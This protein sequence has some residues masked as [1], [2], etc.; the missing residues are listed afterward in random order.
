MQVQFVG[1]T[2]GTVRKPIV[3][4]HG[5]P[6]RRA[7]IDQLNAEEFIAYAARV[8]NPA[9]QHN[10]AT[11]DKLLG[12][13]IRNKHW[14][15]FEM[16]SM[17]VEIT[18]S[19][20]IAPQILRHRSF[21]FQEFSLRYAEAVDFEV[22]EARRQDTKNRQNSIDDMS[23]EDK[24]WF[25]ETQALINGACFDKY[26]QAINRGIAKEQARFLLP[27]STQTKLYMS[28]TARSWIHY[29]DVRDQTGVQKEHRDI[30]IECKKIFIANFPHT[31]KALEWK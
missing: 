20:G 13:L 12:Y 2:Q 29:I 17:A 28:G 9:N 16:V 14:S 21:S 30:A 10:T 1:I 15:P 27:L 19:R 4:E 6:E 7:L 24:A 26:K 8:S 18:T 11:T 22:Y 23:D 5:S 31:S 25:A 3:E